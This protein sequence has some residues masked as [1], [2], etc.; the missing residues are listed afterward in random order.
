M[1]NGS[2]RGLVPTVGA[3]CGSVGWVVLSGL[4]G[5][6]G[7]WTPLFTT[8]T[9][10]GCNR[11]YRIWRWT[12]DRVGRIHFCSKSCADSWTRG[13]TSGFRFAEDR[14]KVRPYPVARRRV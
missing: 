9:C 11:R 3:S 7:E 12:K 2:F 8:K 13:Y 6:F 10:L 5:S 1:G 4:M 14:T